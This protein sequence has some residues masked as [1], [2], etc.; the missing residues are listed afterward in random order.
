MKFLL[1]FVL[2]VFMSFS[3]FSQ[4]EE[5]ATYNR[6]GAFLIQTGS[7]LFNP[8]FTTG[9]GASIFFNEGES[10]TSISADLGTFLSN[11]TALRFGLG[12]VD[13]GFSD[14][15]TLS[16]GI[17]QY[18]NGNIP[19]DLKLSRLS[20]S[21]DSEYLASL[22]LGYAISLADNILLEPSY[23]IYINLEDTDNNVTELRF[24][25]ALLID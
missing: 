6:K 24:A 17:K 13:A 1:S 18:I 8:F 25:F 16:A 11:N 12:Y 22:H 5:V 23:G 14:I 3:L 10:I 20:A 2:C 7:G 21:G 19:L 4:A 15:T 9:S